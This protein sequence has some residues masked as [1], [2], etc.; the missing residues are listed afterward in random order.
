MRPIEAGTCID[1]ACVSRWMLVLVLVALPLPVRAIDFELVA[2][3]R[4]AM[5]NQVERVD[6][7]GTPGG[8]SADLSGAIRSILDDY[9]TADLA[10]FA[11]DGEYYYL[12]NAQ[13]P[14]RGGR[15][16]IF[17]LNLDGSGGYTLSGRFDHSETQSFRGFATDGDYF[18]WLNT[19]GSGDWGGAS[20]GRRLG[21]RQPS[22]R[23]RA[24]RSGTRGTIGTA[25]RP[26]AL[27]STY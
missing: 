8:S 18:Y 2:L 27:G 19:S 1:K 6:E 5:G 12:Y 21:T 17:R 9:P 7:H 20:F 11:T 3:S 25:W 22:T 15:G 4:I 16:E 13:T 24:V 23:S 10:G 26:T 14:T